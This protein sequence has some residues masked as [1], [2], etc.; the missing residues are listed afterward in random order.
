MFLFVGL[1]LR[2]LSKVCFEWVWSSSK[3]WGSKKVK[4][5]PL[6]HVAHDH[7]SLN[8]RSEMVSPE[9]LSSERARAFTVTNSSE[10]CPCFVEV[11]T[12]KLL[13]SRTDRFVSHFVVFSEQLL[14]GFLSI[15]TSTTLVFM[16]DYE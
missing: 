3:V 7:Y 5:P 11:L 8:L 16:L 6:S 2:I 15:S 12:S 10:S 14:Q 4:A 13:H 1:G 9:I